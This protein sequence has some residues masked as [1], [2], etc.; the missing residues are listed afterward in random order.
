MS[1]EIALSEIQEFIGSFWFHYDSG[2]YAEVAAS[3]TEDATYISRSE[4]G[5][6]PFEEILAAHLNGKA[7]IVAWLTEHREG[8]PYPLRH[9]GTNI[10]RTGSDGDTTAVRSYIFVTQVANHV[11]F[12]VSSGVLETGIRRGPNGLQFTRF[13][14]IMDTDDSVPFAEFKAAANAAA[15]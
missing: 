6:S 13:D 1:S 3:F 14:L 5:A 12:A 15:N 10:H 9:N 7:E 11:P 2:H 4:S 8:S